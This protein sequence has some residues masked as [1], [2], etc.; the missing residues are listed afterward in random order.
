M[1]TVT[2]QIG[3]TDN[4]LTQREWAQFCEELR[5]LIREHS[6]DIFFQGGSTWDAPLQNACWVCEVDQASIVPLKTAIKPCREKFRQ[7]AVAF[8]L[9]ETDFV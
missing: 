9:G 2:I 3:N 8:S 7:D 5:T 4:K 6:S 1:P